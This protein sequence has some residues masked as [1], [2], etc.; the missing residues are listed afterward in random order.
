MLEDLASPL[1][2]LT[3]V[4]FLLFFHKVRQSELWVMRQRL[5]PW[6][7]RWCSLV[8]N[9]KKLKQPTGLVVLLKSRLG[10]DISWLHHKSGA[11][12]KP[13]CVIWAGEYVVYRSVRDHW[14][15]Q[16]W[17]SVTWY[18][19]WCHHYSSAPTWWRPCLLGVLVRLVS[20]CQLMNQLESRLQPSR[21]TGFIPVC[22]DRQKDP[23][24]FIIS[25]PNR[26]MLQK[27]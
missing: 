22:S 3:L 8:V 7:H 6:H 13:W 23:K 27:V 15:N 1:T 12:H 11:N 26:G 5:T 20:V 19:W 2:F 14:T 18:R 16:I 4:E 10:C 25:D 17:A 9:N 21:I 24:N